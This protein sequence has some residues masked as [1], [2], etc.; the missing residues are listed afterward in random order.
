MSFFKKVK[1]GAS[2]AADKAQQAVEIQRLNSQVSGIVKEIERSKLQIGEAVYQAYVKG[3]L[4]LAEPSIVAGSQQI[5][6]HE[7][8]IK[9]LELKIKELK[10]QKDCPSC[11]NIV[12]F[13]AK[14]CPGCGHKFEQEESITELEETE[15]LAPT[16]PS[17]QALL[18]QD[19]KFCAECGQAV[20]SAS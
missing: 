19:S 20:P 7:V 14:F 10:N 9:G 1:E 3:D 18:E 13:D 8:T 12:V 5:T 11:N 4:S 16:C 6:L 17:C 15:A 2:K